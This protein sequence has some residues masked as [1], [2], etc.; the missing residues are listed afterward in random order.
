MDHDGKPLAADETDQ[1]HHRSKGVASVH[2]R[3]VVTWIAIFP[4]AAVGMSLLAHLAP[5][6]PTIVRALVLTAVV[7]PASV[8]VTVP[9]LLAVALALPARRARGSDDAVPTP[10]SATASTPAHEPC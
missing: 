2:T 3:A 9:R 8:Y 10:S 7:V 6:W 1:H 5:A 4:L